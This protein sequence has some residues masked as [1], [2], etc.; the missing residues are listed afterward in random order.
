MNWNIVNHMF[1]KNPKYCTRSLVYC[2]DIILNMLDSPKSMLWCCPIGCPLWIDVSPFWQA[3]HNLFYSIDNHGRPSKVRASLLR[4]RRQWKEPQVSLAA[5]GEDCGTGSWGDAAS[6]LFV[7]SLL[8]EQLW[9]SAQ[10]KTPSIIQPTDQDLYNGD[11]Q[12]FGS[13]VAEA[14][15]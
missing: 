14:A 9:S 6:Q 8:S 10:E 12:S 5:G 1:K 3:R 7:S 4:R 15:W 11:D 2:A 13:A